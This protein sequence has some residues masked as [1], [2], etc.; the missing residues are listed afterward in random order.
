MKMASSALRVL[1]MAY[2][3]LDHK[4]TNEE[5]NSME[6]DLIYIGMVGMI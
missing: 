3:E 1:A 6:S 2:K 4:P 5:M